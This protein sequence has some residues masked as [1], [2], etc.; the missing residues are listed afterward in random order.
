MVNDIIVQVGRLTGTLTPWPS[1]NRCRL[2][3]L[4]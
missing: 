3:A 4:P 1:W 2:A